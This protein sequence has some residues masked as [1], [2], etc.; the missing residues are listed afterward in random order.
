MTWMETTAAPRSRGAVQGALRAL[1]AARSWRTTPHALLGLPL[2][3]GGWLVIAG[4][5]VGWAA[6]LWSL[7]EG[8]TGARWLAVAYVLVVVAVP[9]VAPWFV[10]ACGA[11][12]RRRFRAVLGVGAP[13]APPRARGGGRLR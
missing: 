1:G 13:G 8:P 5:G 12:Q 3:I 4:L 7:I 6:A 2:G 11:L 10:R 9:V